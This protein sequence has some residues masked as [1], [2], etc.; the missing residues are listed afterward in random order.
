MLKATENHHTIH[1]LLI[2]WA[3]NRSDSE[4]DLVY[5]IKCLKKEIKA[6]KALIE[7]LKEEVK[8]RIQD[9]E[10]I[11]ADN[12]CKWSDHHEVPNKTGGASKH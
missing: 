4:S 9:Y 3:P 2:E 11:S 12:Q 5:K 7:D 1:E 8:R 6:Q 10:A